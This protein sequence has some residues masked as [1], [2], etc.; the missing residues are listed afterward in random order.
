LSLGD[1]LLLARVNCIDTLESAL[2]AVSDQQGRDPAVLAEIAERYRVLAIA[3]LLED[4]DPAPFA[5]LL[6]LS[7]QTEC[8]LRSID[9]AQHPA[10]LIGSRVEPFC[11]AL[12]AGDLQSAR[13]I[14]QLAPVHHQDGWEYEDDFLA[15]HF[16]QRLLV[17][18][19]D[20][21]LS[22]VLD[23]W[24]QVLEGQGSPSLD[25]SR[26]LLARDPEALDEALRATVQDLLRK[27]EVW[28]KS[29]TYN[30]QVDA[31]EGSLF[32]NGLAVI[33]LAD[34]RGMSLP[35]EYELMPSLARVPLGGAL[36][37]PESWRLFQTVRAL[38]GG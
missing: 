34:M 29:T 3:V 24:E 4:G 13:T 7:G 14:A 30:A 10:Q 38:A 15:A 16:L 27:Q 2:A 22:R 33:R 12:V 20:A 1:A 5:S 6:A 35:E 23:R 18:S 32:I 36:P 26:A 25:V 37:P 28:R 9:L 11:D 17:G 31:T 21:A 19:D 8:F